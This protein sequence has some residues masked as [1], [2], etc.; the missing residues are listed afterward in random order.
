LKLHHV[1]AGMYRVGNT[2]IVVQ[3]N[4]EWG[5]DIIK[6]HRGDVTAYGMSW[7]RKRD[8][9]EYLKKNKDELLAWGS[10]K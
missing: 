10:A 3:R 5:W 6:H 8:A 4:I 9:V 2:S 7:P 1:E